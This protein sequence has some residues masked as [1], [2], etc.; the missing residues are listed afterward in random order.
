MTGAAQFAHGLA[1]DLSHRF[2]P[3]LA[4]QVALQITLYAGGLLER[5]AGFQ[6]QTGL[7]A[8]GLQRGLDAGKVPAPRPPPSPTPSHTRTEIGPS[9]VRRRRM[10]AV[11]E[12]CGAVGT[13]A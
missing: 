9:A 11:V 6:Q 1:A 10:R 12:L 3:D 5:V 2:M 4:L 7:M 8:Q 13:W